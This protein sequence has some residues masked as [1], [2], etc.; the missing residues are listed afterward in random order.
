LSLLPSG[1]CLS[2]QHRLDLEV[3]LP[4]LAGVVVERAEV[5]GAL[6]CV[7]ARVRA[8]DAACPRCGCR[9]G[10]VHSRY[11]R[12]LADA[13]I[14]GRRVVIRL[15]VRRF[16]CDQ[17]GCPA[18]TFAEQAGG[19]T[20]RY[21]RRSPPLERMLAQIALALAGR[22]GARL[23]GLL[24]LAAGRSS[25]LRLVMAM[26]DP[27]ARVVTVLGVDDFAFRKGRVYGTVLID[28]ATRRPVDLLADREAGTLAGWLRG[29]P[30]VQVICRDRAGAYADG[31]RRGAP[32][33]VQVA[34]R[35]HLWHNLAGHAEKEVTRHHRCLNA[36]DPGPEPG[37]P[38]GA[39]QEPGLQAIAAAAAQQRTGA[40]VLV[41]RTTERHEAVQ[42]L[43][44]QGK[45]ITAIMRELGLS[46]ATVHRFTRAASLDELLANARAG[47]P[48]IL[49]PHKPC[50][51]QRWNEGCTSIT[52]LHAEITARGYRGRY[53]TT[54]EY[55]APFRKLA[56]AP[57]APPPRARDITGWML[58]H[59]RSLN[60][61][62]Q[63]SLQQI[64]ERCPHLDALAGH[65]TEFARILTGL[66]GDRLGAWTAAAS[67]AGLPELRSFT[68]GIKNDYNAVLA[69]LTLPYNSGAVEGNV[70]RIKMIKRQMYGR[71]TFPLLRKR[72]LLTT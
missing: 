47:R 42:A 58:R 32:G 18:V 14:G 43:R 55:L 24:G 59:P 12:R 65:I 49:D 46:K 19:L 41:R 31:A 8:G 11:G 4:H 2:C 10:R 36:P 50:L 13:G 51:H 34:D 70:N 1:G 20:S 5:A 45:G 72:V 33:A 16:F 3:L 48:S 69:G 37:R 60:A 28:L 64:R 7:W 44:A 23:A 56:A 9:S 57:P 6:V 40:S 62:E 27:P 21:S 67:T 53:Q 52:R 17:P 66:H 25:L 26:P 15:R 39:G 30:G 22:A 29:H 68:T 54:R 38:A 63:A 71:A 35:W 61:A